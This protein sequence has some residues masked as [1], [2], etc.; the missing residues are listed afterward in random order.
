MKILKDGSVFRIA[1]EST[2]GGFETRFSFAVNSHDQMVR[3]RLEISERELHW[4]FVGMLPHTDP[5]LFLDK[6]FAVSEFRPEI[7]HAVC[8]FFNRF[9]MIFADSG[10]MHNQYSEPLRAFLN[11]KTKAE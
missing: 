7:A 1:L 5:M 6:N 11:A 4:L 9:A 2:P 10:Y 3:P 8:A